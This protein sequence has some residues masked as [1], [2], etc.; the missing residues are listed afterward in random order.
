MYKKHLSLLKLLA[1]TKNPK[2]IV[3]ELDTDIL[4]CLTDCCYNILK[5]NIPLSVTQESKL[6]KH[7]K[8]LRHMV[9]KKISQKKKKEILQKGGFLPALLAPIIASVAAPLVKSIFG[10]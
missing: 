8:H 9:G 3:H 7:K 10:S 5:G 6:K 1:K 2:Y 4:D